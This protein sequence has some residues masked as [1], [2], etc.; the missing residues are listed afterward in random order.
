MLNAH[1]IIIRPI[2][3]EKNTRLNEDSKYIFEVAMETNKIEVKKAIEEIFGVNVTSVNIINVRGKLKKRRT[4]QGITQGY[5]RDW[6]KAIVTLT[7]DSKPIEIF[8]G[9]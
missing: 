3:T 6:K 1:K 7:P 9:V 8:E 4:R 5:T 2:I